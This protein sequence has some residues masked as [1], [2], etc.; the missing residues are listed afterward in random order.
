MRPGEIRIWQPVTVFAWTWDADVL[1]WEL[2]PDAGSVGPLVEV[3]EGPWQQRYAELVGV[4]GAE[5]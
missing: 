2:E 1:R 5:D 3:D 4:E